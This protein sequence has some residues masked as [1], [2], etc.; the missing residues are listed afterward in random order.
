MDRHDRH[1][2]FI[3]HATVKKEYRRQGIGKKLVDIIG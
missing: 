2:G 1:K 3:Y